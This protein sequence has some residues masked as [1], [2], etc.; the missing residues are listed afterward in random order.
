[1]PRLEVLLERPCLETD[2]GGPLTS[3]LVR[4]LADCGQPS[5]PPQ[6]VPYWTDAGIFR[7]HAEDVI[8]FGPA[9]SGAHEAVEW[10]E[11]SSVHRTSE[12]LYRLALDYCR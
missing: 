11:L 10:V 5:S 8:L 12:I 1:M 9:G 4:A 7:E 6:G 3:S 2:P